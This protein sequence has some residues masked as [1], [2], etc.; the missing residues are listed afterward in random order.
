VRIEDALTVVELVWWGA[1]GGL[2]VEAVQLLR[3]TKRVNGLP[4]KVDGEPALGVLLLSVGMRLFIG[5]GLATAAGLSDQV[6]G[7]MGA[8]AVGVCAPL[9][10]DQ[11][12]S[13]VPVAGASPAADA[14][15]ASV[16][17]PPALAE[18]TAEAGGTDV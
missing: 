6:S 1:F 4:W 17:A 2:G 10:I 9:I 5:C 13:G 14:A 8:L 7:P 18:V 15:A 16:N 3:S 11:I 12:G